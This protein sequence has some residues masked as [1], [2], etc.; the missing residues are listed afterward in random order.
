MARVKTKA[1]T[2]AGPEG[3]ELTIEACFERLDQILDKMEEEGTGL[4]DAFRLYEEGLGLVRHAESGID[5]VEKKI[6]ILQEEA[7]SDSME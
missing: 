4:E 3:E 7:G 6:R 1:E 2:P 5:R